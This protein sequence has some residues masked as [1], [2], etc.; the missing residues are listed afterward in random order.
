[1]RPSPALLFAGLSSLAVL[2]AVVAGIA[3]IGTPGQIRQQR[4]DAQRV[5]DLRMIAASVDGYRERHGALP[6]GLEDLRRYEAGRGYGSGLELEDAASSQAY[7]YRVTG[8]ASYEICARFDTDARQAGASG[9]PDFW[10]H[11]P[12]RHC[13]SLEAPPA[14]PPAPG[15]G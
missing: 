3:V 14:P 6:A 10:R 13:F 2:A 12:G 4:L 11:G 8:P 9:T 5:A 1:M 7:E 15:S